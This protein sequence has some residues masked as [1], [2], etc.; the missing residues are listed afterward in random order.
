VFLSDLSV[1]QMTP[2]E[3]LTATVVIMLTKKENNIVAVEEIFM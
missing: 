2:M 1:K 3:A